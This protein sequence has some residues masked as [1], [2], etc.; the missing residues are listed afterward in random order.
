MKMKHREAEQKKIKNANA[1][2]SANKLKLTDFSSEPALMTVYQQKVYQNDGK[3]K[4]LNQKIIAYD[5]SMIDS[6]PIT[7]QNKTTDSSLPA[8]YK[9]K[10]NPLDVDTNCDY[11]NMDNLD[12]MEPIKQT[13]FQYRNTSEDTLNPLV[14]GRSQSEI[15]PSRTASTSVVVEKPQN[16][17]N[18]DYDDIDMFVVYDDIDFYG[19]RNNNSTFKEEFGRPLTPE[20]KPT[21]TL[22]NALENLDVLKPIQN[23]SGHRKSHSKT[24][25]IL[26]TFRAMLSPFY[27]NTNQSISKTEDS[28]KRLDKI[29]SFL[30]I[31]GFTARHQN[32]NDIFKMNSAK[33]RGRD[34]GKLSEEDAY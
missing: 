16:E 17:K 25:S 6:V 34:I 5:D 30:K 28:S 33:K 3:K 14:L 23:E 20:H 8:I 10:S 27:S 21:E 7:K 32:V 22:D 29:N 18:D 15:L 1:G 12:D 19:E 13:I 4:K 31:N 24:R 9:T 2:N 26:G 11:K